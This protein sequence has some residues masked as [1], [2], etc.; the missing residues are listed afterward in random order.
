MNDTTLLAIRAAVEAALRERRELREGGCYDSDDFC[1]MASSGRLNP[2]RKI[3]PGAQRVHGISDAD[4]A[5]APRW[6]DMEQRA[7]WR[8]LAEGSG[9]E[10]P[11]IFA[12]HNVAEADL[13]WMRAWGYLPAGYEPPLKLRVAGVSSSQITKEFADRAVL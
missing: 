13:A 2:G 5:K 7:F 10:L 11:A 9:D 6:D 1:G 3:D 8:A 4:V 12:G